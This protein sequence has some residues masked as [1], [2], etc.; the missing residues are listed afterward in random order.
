LVFPSFVIA[1]LGRAIH[2]KTRL[3]SLSLS[4]GKERENRHQLYAKHQC[5]LKAAIREMDFLQC[6][7]TQSRNRN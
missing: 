1:R 3:L 7:S 5:P 6:G 4:K 2:R